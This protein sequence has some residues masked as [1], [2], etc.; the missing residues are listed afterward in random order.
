M[1]KDYHVISTILGS[2]LI[3]LLLAGCGDQ[4]ILEKLGF[5]QANSF[6][7]AENGQLEVA[8]TMP[9]AE[10]KTSAQRVVLSTKA[11]TGKEARMKLTREINL[12][13][14]SGQ[15]RNSLFGMSLARNG[16]LKHLDTY[17]RDPSIS[18]RVKLT[19]V[20]GSA[21]KMLEQSY[22]QHPIISR[23]IEGLLQK[24]AAGRSIPVSTVY[25]FIRDYYDDGIDPVM[26][27]LRNKDNNII[28]D[29]VALF[30]DDRYVAEIPADDGLVFS[31]L[32]GS[33]KQGDLSIHLNEGGAN[34]GDTVML[35][36]IVSNR[37]VKVKRG[38]GG[39]PELTIKVSLKGTVIEY[40]GD[41]S[42]TQPTEKRLLEK[43]MEKA[44]NGRGDRLI[45]LMQKN[46][47]DGLGLGISVRS[48]SSYREWKKMKWP[49]MYPSVKAKCVFSIEILNAG[50]I[51][52]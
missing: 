19:I 45:S 11:R 46:N 21:K 2:M 9:K 16:L 37:K 39:K 50:K 5:M 31:F 8:I 34:G 15:L 36:S 35:T 49:E 47:A 23:Y 25:T 22:I 38:A 14:V 1:R 29:G 10:Q 44:L 7:L 33:F 12:Q 52:E 27:V 28:I 18:P 42:I 26:A 4:R 40:T 24:E 13:I 32:R 48:H 17:Q 20:R 6:D 43:G 3:V 51:V 30:H 41:H